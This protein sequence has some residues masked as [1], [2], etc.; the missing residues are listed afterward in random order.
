MP[1]YERCWMMRNTWSSHDLSSHPADNRAYEWGQTRPSSPSCNRL[2]CVHSALFTPRSTQQQRG[3]DR[4][5][6]LWHGVPWRCQAPPTSRHWNWPFA[7]IVSPLALQTMLSLH[8]RQ[9]TCHPVRETFLPLIKWATQSR[10]PHQPTCFIL[11]YIKALHYAKWSKTA[12]KR[13]IQCSITYTWSLK[14]TKN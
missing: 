3:L 1:P 4:R 5:L 14:N 9:P 11:S 7:G 13:Q 6:K 12:R 10:S 2:L 8:E